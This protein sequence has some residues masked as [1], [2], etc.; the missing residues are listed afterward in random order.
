MDNGSFQ[1]VPKEELEI[2]V[3]DDFEGI[4]I[5]TEGVQEEI[6]NPQKEEEEDPSG[7][8]FELPG[9]GLKAFK[10]LQGL[11]GDSSA[12]GNSVRTSS[13][14]SAPR[15]SAADMAAILNRQAAKIHGRVPHRP[16]GNIPGQDEPAGEKMIIGISGEF[17]GESAPAPVQTPREPAVAGKFD[18]LLEFLEESIEQYHHYVSNIGRNG[19]A[20]ANLGYFRDDI[21]EVLD[22]LKYEESITL[23]P[24]WEIIVKIDLELRAKAPIYVREVGYE[25]FKQYQI[26]N[27]PPLT[28]WWWYL[29][30]QVAPP[31]VQPKFWEI[32]KKI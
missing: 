14:S 31:V 5:L 17:A 6:L 28:H 25:N 7:V 3:P 10:D 16:G 8:V 12:Q 9:Y 15:E 24:Y 29:N 13:G 11:S 2:S 22:M 32:W 21:Q 4:P 18:D 20:A 30:R 19:L 1:G 26:V 27:D 23:R